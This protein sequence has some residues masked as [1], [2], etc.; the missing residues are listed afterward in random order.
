MSNIGIPGIIL[1][2]IVFAL[3][4][5]FFLSFSAFIRKLLKNSDKS[6]NQ[7]NIDSRLNRIEDELRVINK[8]MDNRDS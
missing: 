5:L 6:H 2:I 1:I 4:A 3:I 8:K 7:T